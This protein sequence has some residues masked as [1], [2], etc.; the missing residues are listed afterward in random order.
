M[1]FIC[2]SINDTCLP[3][4]RALERGEEPSYFDK[5]LIPQLTADEVTLLVDGQRAEIAAFGSTPVQAERNQL[6]PG[7]H[8]EAIFPSGLSRGVHRLEVL[9]A[10]QTRT[11]AGEDV[12]ERGQGQHFQL[13]YP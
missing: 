2:W 7:W 12:L 9:V 11:L 4:Y 8:V 3:L 13:V 10:H 6:V 5:A 1:R